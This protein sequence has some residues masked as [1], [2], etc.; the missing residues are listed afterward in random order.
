MR[1]SLLGSALALSAVAVAAPSSAAAPLSLV[2]IGD[3]GGDSDEHPTT[4]AQ[5]AAAAGMAKIAD[6]VNA[7]SILLLGDNF[8]TH[9]VSSSTSSR[10]NETFEQVG[11]VRYCK[12][13]ALTISGLCCASPLTHRPTPPQVY[14]VEHFGKLPFHV[15]AGNHDH[16]GNVQ[17]QLDYHGSARWNFPSVSGRVWRGGYCFSGGLR[18][19]ESAR[20]GDLQYREQQERRKRPEGAQ[21]KR[22]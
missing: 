17:A 13:S 6:E 10:F 20:G 1:S 16:Y 18:Q 7:D 19:L 12:C 4:A 11:F 15:V 5:V 8:Y 3:W 14:D 22:S 21:S 9:G 2:A